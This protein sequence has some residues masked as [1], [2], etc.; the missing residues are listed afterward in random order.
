MIGLPK[1]VFYSSMKLLNSARCLEQSRGNLI[2]FFFNELYSLT[3]D[4]SS[5]NKVCNSG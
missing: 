3:K 4:Q 5:Q 2:I 1:T